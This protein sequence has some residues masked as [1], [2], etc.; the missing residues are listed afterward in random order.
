MIGKESKQNGNASLSEVLEILEDRK[1]ERELTYEQQI[2]MEHAKKFVVA[3][4]TEQKTK[5]ALEALGIRSG[6]AVM[7]IINIMPKGEMLLKQ[8]LAN[9]RR[10]FTDEEVK[11]VLS[12][13]NQK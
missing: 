10:T 6:Q 5:K 7:S 9:E 3:K 1:K 2:A 13:V 8:I 4:V 12:I 11:R